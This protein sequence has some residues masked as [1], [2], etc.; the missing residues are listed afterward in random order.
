MTPRMLRGTRIGGT[1]MMDVERQRLKS[2]GL[3]ALAGQ[4]DRPTNPVG[5]APMRRA[6]PVRS[7]N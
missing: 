2:N 4:N 6:N 5:G 1:I 3:H 7:W